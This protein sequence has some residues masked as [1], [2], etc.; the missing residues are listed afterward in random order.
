M[1]ATRSR[2][3]ALIREGRVE[4]EGVRREKAGFEVKPGWRVC[5]EI[6]QAAP[7]RA[8]AQDLPVR[9]L[10]QDGELAVV[11]KPSGMT[12]HPAPGNPDGTLV[13]ALLARLDSLSGIGGELRP[14]IVHRIDKDTSG[15]LLVAKNDRAHAALSEQIALHTVN[16]A[17]ITLVEGRM[18]EISGVVDGPIGRHPVDRKKMAIVPGGKQA[19]THWRV[20]EQMQGAVCWNACWKPGEPIRFGYIWPRWGIRCWGI[21]FTGEKPAGTSRAGSFCTPI[22]W[23]LPTRPPGNA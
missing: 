8:V 7:A 19:R 10:Y 6:P 16:R 23:D 13:N 15:I 11:Y 20:L 5:G 12:V 4:V 1:E 3:A 9:I 17:Y 18:K 14:G 22:G 21:R 2:A